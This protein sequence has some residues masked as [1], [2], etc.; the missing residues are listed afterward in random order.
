MTLDFQLSERL[1]LSCFSHLHCHL[2]C[3]VLLKHALKA[4][5]FETCDYAVHMQAMSSQRR[6][7]SL[8]RRRAFWHCTFRYFCDRETEDFVW[9]EDL[10]IYCTLTLNSRWIYFLSGSIAS[11]SFLLFLFIFLSMLTLVSLFYF[12]MVFFIIMIWST[13]FSLA[14]CHY[15]LYL[16]MNR[17]NGQCLFFC[18]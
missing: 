6:W 16:K 10:G 15:Y 14:H 18:F 2:K 3:L 12:I 5:R 17:E 9:W 1:R 13:K 11:F 7:S 4:F 8:G